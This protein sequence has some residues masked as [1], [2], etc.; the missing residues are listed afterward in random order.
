MMKTKSIDHDRQDRAYLRRLTKLSFAGRRWSPESI[1]EVCDLLVPWNHNIKLPFGIYTAHC[2]DYYPAHEEIMSVV[3]HQLGG[4]FAGKRVLDVGCLEGYFSAEC[5]LQGADVVGIDGKTLNIR[6]CE[7]VRSVLGVPNVRFIR[8]DAMRVTRKKYGPFDVVLA[9]GLL[10]HL[11]DPFTFLANM[12]GLCDGSLLIDSHVALADQPQA[13]S[14]GWSPD[15]S[16]LRQFRAGKRIYSGRLFREFSP[17]TSRVA[18][19]L[20]PTASLRNNLSVWLTED[21]LTGLLRD[22]G[23]GQVCKLVYPQRGGTWWSDVRADARVLVLT[24]KRKPFGSKVFG[25]STPGGGE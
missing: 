9:L 11:R 25:G 22:V 5:A 13:L 17:G 7:F 15:L 18:K 23:F 6:K 1:R 14:D 10:Y 12:A 4:A 24:A 3:N 20:S 16:P 19:N 2:P 21:S 8:D